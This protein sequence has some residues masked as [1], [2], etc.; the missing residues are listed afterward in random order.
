MNRPLLLA[1]FATAGVLSAQG[2]LIRSFPIVTTG[3]VPVGLEHNS[4]GELIYTD[5]GADEAGVMDVNG[6]IRFQANISATSSNPIGCTYVVNPVQRLYVTDS[7]D[8]DVDVYDRHG[9]Y[10]SSFS[11]AAQTTF[12]EGIT[13]RTINDHLYVVDGAGGNKVSEYDTAGTWIADFPI[14]GFSPDGIAWDPATDTFWVYD[15]GTD[16]CRNYDLSFTELRNFRGPSS[17]GFGTG[18]GVAIIGAEVFICATGTDTICV[19]DPDAVVAAN[20]PYGAG[21]PQPATFYE[22]FTGGSPFDLANSAIWLQPNPFGGYTVVSDISV[23]FPF[24]T[25][26]LGAGDDQLFSAQALGFSMQTP[27]GVQ[28]TVDIDSNGRCGWGLAGSDFSESVGEFTA[29]TIL[30]PLWDDLNAAAGGAVYFD[31]YPSVALITW[32]QIP[33]F[34][35]ANSNTV[36]VQLFESGDIKIIWGDVALLDCIV[37]ASFGLGFDPGATDISASI[38]FNTQGGAPL[39]LSADADP[40][41]GTSANMIVSNVPS[42]TL[43]AG[44]FVGFVPTAV[45]LDGIGMPGCFD[46]AA[47]DVFFGVFP[48]PGTAL[49]VAYPNDPSLLGGSVFWQ[50]FAITPGI[51]LFGLVLSNGLETKLGDF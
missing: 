33:E 8:D 32:D 6:V 28:S 22:Q 27:A 20:I 40:V 47:G 15:S 17:N 19:Y 46:Y 3:G 42:G 9:V 44:L 5:I 14:L 31:V 11:V 21:C 30:A 25:N 50:A 48:L 2:P 4:F 12:P 16:T 29:Q 18:E 10:I 34:G 1:L 45:P 39:G 35:S 38:P 41:L 36:Q 7:T 23:I 37:G 51:N 13:H 24:F 49:S 26:N 43:A